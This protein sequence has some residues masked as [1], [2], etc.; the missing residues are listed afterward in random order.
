M[1]GWGGDYSSRPD[2]MHYEFLGS[3]TDCQRLIAQLGNPIESPIVLT[4]TLHL[5]DRGPIVGHVQDLLRWFAKRHSANNVDPGGT[6]NNYGPRTAH[7]VLAFK[8][9][10][11]DLETAFG[12][13]L[14]F[15][16]PL[17]NSC[18]VLTLGALEYWAAVK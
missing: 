6:D 16:A 11:F 14:T 8:T 12:S 2:C 10:I 13:H 15:H 5:G 18:G 7:A 9:R 17:D 1:F 4:H 3:P